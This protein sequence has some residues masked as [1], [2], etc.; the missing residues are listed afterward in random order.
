MFLFFYYKNLVFSKWP[1]FS[2]VAQLFPICVNTTHKLGTWATF[3]WFWFAKIY[4]FFR[5][6][7]HTWCKVYFSDH[8]SF[9]RSLRKSGPSFLDLGHFSKRW[10]N[11]LW[12]SSDHFFYYNFYNKLFFFF[13]ILIYFLIFNFRSFFQ[14]WIFNR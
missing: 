14:F 4:V 6:F 7:E 5:F 10:A 11:F 2:K 9:S 1:I 13:L 3:L 12:N 8:F